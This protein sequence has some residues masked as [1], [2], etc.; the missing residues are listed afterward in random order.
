MILTAGEMLVEFLSVRRNCGLS[1]PGDFLGPM[2]SGA[3]AIF[4]DQAARVGANSAIYGSVG[5]DAFGHSLLDR[6]TA[7]GVDTRHV[8]VHPDATTGTAFVSY[9]DSGERVFVFHLNGT[10]ADRLPETPRLAPGTILHVSGASL[11]NSVIRARILEL[12]ERA[13]RV[14]KI[15]FDPNV[16]PELLGDQA[17]G[18]AIQTILDATDIFLPSEGDLA[19]LFPGASFANVCADMH[20]K[21]T[22]IVVL[23]RGKNGATGSDGNRTLSL[24]G[25]MV[26]EVDPTGAGDCFCGTFVGLLDQGATFET[27]L[28][29]ANAAGALHVTRAGPMEWNP[30]RI[31]IENFL[32]GRDQ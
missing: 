25:H 31:E 2:P 22:E 11:G 3:P 32:E 15:S 8:T 7:D 19:T 5:N 21:G 18:P 28:T 26:E 24:D 1:E 14:G 23:K 17:I 4:A 9:Y 10:A 29:S 16:R 13:R 27:A 30:T 12:V 20:S 6:L